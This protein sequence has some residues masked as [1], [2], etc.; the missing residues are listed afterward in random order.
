MVKVMFNILV[1][2]GAG[3]IG[4]YTVK[5]LLDL[6]YNVIIVDDLSTSTFES[7]EGLD[8]KFHNVD[9]RNANELEK[10]FASYEKIDYVFDFAARLIVEESVENPELYYDVNVIGLKNV[11][12]MTVKYNVSNFIFSSTAA[13]HGLLDKKSGLISEEDPTIPSNPYGTTKLIG[14]F[15]VKD[16]SKKY[17][18][19]FVIFRY[20]N[21]VGHVKYGTTL[22]DLTTILPRIV[23]AIQNDVPL[24][25]NGTD[26]DTPDG[27]CVRDFIHLED[28]VQ[29]HINLI[30][31]L[32]SE[33]KGIYNLSIGK[34]TGVIELIHE[35]EKCLNIKINYNNGPR[36]IGDPIVSAASNK[37]YLDTFPWEIKY[38][39][40]GEMIE[41]TY[42]SWEKYQEFNTKGRI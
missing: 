33:T 1:T 30:G 40:I 10:V 16:Y 14:E 37:K 20:F 21:V 22:S 34:G 27:T 5:K 36:R 41:E 2:G 11:L 13:V 8:V 7:L 17:G 32:N 19:N 4:S 28:L 6:K 25:V 39:E 12:D 38:P 35:T 18:F 23:D 42:K 24:T 31:R 9:I 3:Y 26:Y 29:A 15:M